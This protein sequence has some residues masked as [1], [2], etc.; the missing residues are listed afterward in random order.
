MT[1][2][3][4][5]RNARLV[6]FTFAA[7]PLFFFFNSCTSFTMK[8]TNQEFGYEIINGRKLAVSYGRHHGVFEVPP[9]EITEVRGEEYPCLADYDRNMDSNG[10]WSGTGLKG[11]RAQE[12]LMQYAIV[13]G[14]IVVRSSTGDDAVVFEEG[15]DYRVDAN[16]WGAVGRLPDGRIGAD[17]P[18]FIDYRYSKLRLD[19]IILSAHGRLVYKRGTPHIA[20][21]VPPTLRNRAVRLAN[22]WQNRRLETLTDDNVFPVTETAFSEPPRAIPTEAQLKLSWALDKL[23]HGQKLRILAWGDSVTEATFCRDYPNG[24]WQEQFVTWLRERYPNAEIELISQGW[25]GRNTSSFLA[26]PPG[27]EHNYE[28]K[29]LGVKPDL[30]ISEFVNDT[31]LPME[32]IT[33]NYKRVRDDLMA[34]HIS[35]I[36]IAPH[37][38]KPS[39]MNCDREKDIDEDPR[40][41]TQFIRQFAAENDNI[42]IADGAVR[43]GR[44][45][46]Q[47]IPHTTLMVN[48]INHPNET[49][50]KIFVEALKCLF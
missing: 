19:S 36:I 21:P 7:F 30:I 47:G 12:C 3:I 17:Q 5:R 33:A 32:E 34:M 48:G 2:G 25:G 35:W 26:E 22:V 9:L 4:L 18:V 6:F 37:Y 46:R 43:Y 23:N 16:E 13:P 11:L 41:Y 28:E 49:G 1:E 10:W 29:V 8:N 40:P 15:R 24:R 44:L 50:M 39:W 38:V 20:N 27:S 42:S 31:G 45:W 14:S